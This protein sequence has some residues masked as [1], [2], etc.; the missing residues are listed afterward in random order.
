M[1]KYEKIVC[2]LPHQMSESY[3]LWEFWYVTFD[4]D[5]LKYFGWF[6]QIK[7]PSKS[8]D[9]ILAKCCFVQTLQIA[10]KIHTKRAS[11]NKDILKVRV[12]FN[13]IYLVQFGFV[14]RRIIKLTF[15]SCMC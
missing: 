11:Y 9:V 2:C 5:W 14:W 6:E 3:N 4:T 12:N 13:E 15:T 7:Y 1:E 8:S 10:T